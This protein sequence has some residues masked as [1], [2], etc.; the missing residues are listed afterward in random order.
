MLKRALLC[1]TA[2]PPQRISHDC[3]SLPVL[4]LP[5]HQPREDRKTHIII[6]RDANDSGRK[7]LCGFAIC[8]G[9]RRRQCP[10]TATRHPT[11][12]MLTFGAVCERRKRRRRRDL[13]NLPGEI[14]KI[15][16][17]STASS[18]NSAVVLRRGLR[19]IPLD[20]RRGAVAPSAPRPPP[21]RNPAE[22]PRR[23]APILFLCKFASKIQPG[24]IFFSSESLNFSWVVRVRRVRWGGG[25]V[26]AEGR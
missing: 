24:R 23:T 21:P 18:V 9:G 19:S 2:K 7:S 13:I 17:F 26:F 5:Q 20:G 11:R 15:T 12:K 25:L 4:P 8:V 1:K 3:F 6:N 22:A 14:I 16:A 10:P